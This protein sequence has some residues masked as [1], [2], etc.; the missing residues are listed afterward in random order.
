[1]TR[2][3]DTRS[4]FF[5]LDPVTG[6]VTHSP[7]C[8]FYKV[9]IQKLASNVKSIYSNSGGNF[10]AIKNDGSTVLWGYDEDYG[11]KLSQEIKDQLQN[12][13]TVVSSNSGFAAL[14]HDGSVVTWGWHMDN[15]KVRDKLQGIKS[16][17]GWRHKH[18]FAA[19]KEDGSV[20]TWG[21][22][23]GLDL[24]R[25]QDRL[26]NVKC[27][28]GTQGGLSALTE[29]G[30]TILWGYDW[31]RQ[32]RVPNDYMDYEE[33]DDLIDVEYTGVK[34]MVANGDA[35]A[36]IKEDG[37]V[38]AWGLCGF[39]G[40]CSAVEHLLKNVVRIDTKW[41]SFHAHRENGEIISW[42]WLGES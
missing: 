38:V 41:S 36:G 25:V 2:F 19:I 35:Y 34:S 27:I 20:F 6:K 30:R 42:G 29:D 23:D 26:K 31:Y 18:V 1:M 11:P 32:E 5:D 37:T 7:A 17:W 21:L 8:A 33:M 3:C 13:K 15:E 9:P 40:D 12:V 16:I 14:R 10:I 22:G 24:T 39:G 28:A 4:G